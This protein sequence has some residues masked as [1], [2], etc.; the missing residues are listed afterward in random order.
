MKER[1]YTINQIAEAA[2]R[3]PHT[4]ARYAA[5][6]EMEP[7]RE[8]KRQRFYSQERAE[9]LIRL[10]IDHKRGNEGLRKVAEQVGAG[11]AA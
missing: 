5:I 6:Y 4:V 7:D 1:L 3:S 11:A 10:V 2:G 8:F 9:T